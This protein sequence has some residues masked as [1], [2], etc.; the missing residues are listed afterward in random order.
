MA[1]KIEY[2]LEDEDSMLER[3]IKII[4]ELR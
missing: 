2:E 4:M 3:E 1:M